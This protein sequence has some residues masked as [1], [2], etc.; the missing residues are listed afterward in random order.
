MLYF[1]FFFSRFLELYFLVCLLFLLILLLL[2]DVISL[3]LFFFI[4]SLS[5]WIHWIDVSLNTGETS[6][7]FFFGH[8]ESMSSLRLKVLCIEINF[9]VSWSVCLNSSL[10][11]FMKR[12]ECLTRETVQVFTSLMRFLLQ[13]FNSRRF[14][15]L[16][17]RPFSYFFF[18]FR[19]LGVRFKYSQEFIVFCFSKYFHAYLIGQ[20]FLQLILFPPFFVLSI[21]HFP[22]A[23]CVTKTKGPSLP[24]YLPIT[25]T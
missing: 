16:L 25:K 11:Y 4:Y 20:S 1:I 12:S 14:L 22:C 10:V 21:V 19:L 6:S 9:L 18:H 13:S 17:R 2:D 8:K 24:Y 5:P 7:S 23:T 15:V 3:F